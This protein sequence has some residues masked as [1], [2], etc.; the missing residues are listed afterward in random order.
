VWATP[1][2]VSFV[3]GLRRDLAAVVAGLSMPYSNGLIEGTNTKIKLLKQQ[4]YDAPGSHCSA[5]E[6]C[7]A[8][9]P[10]H[11]ICARAVVLTVPGVGASPHDYDTG[12]EDGAFP[13]LVFACSTSCASSAIS[14][15]R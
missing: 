13:E 12:V 8:G 4:M 11:L 15:A 1:A 5:S 10:N 9:C 3:R 7:P 2:A 6:S 14:R